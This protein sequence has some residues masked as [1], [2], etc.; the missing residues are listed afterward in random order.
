MK[1]RKSNFELMRIISMLMIIMWHLVRQGGILDN[2]STMLNV[3]LKY[4]TTLLVVHVNSFVILSGY[5]Q[6]SQ[7]FKFSKFLKLVGL[8]WFYKVIFLI[9]TQVFN[10]KEL[11]TLE[12]LKNLSPI[13]YRDYWYLQIYVLLYLISPILNRAINNINKK[14]FQKYLLTLFFIISILPTITMQE[15]FNN[16]YG[17]SLGNF[18]LLYFIGAYLRLYSI[19][20]KIIS[21]NLKQILLVL[22]F[23]ILGFVSLTCHYFSMYIQDFNS[24]TNYISQ[25]L[26][27][28]YCYDSPLVILQT[29]LYFLFFRNLRIKHNKIINKISATTLGIYLIHT[30]RLI[31][32]YVYKYFGFTSYMKSSIRILIF[33]V[34]N[35][36]ALFMLCSIIESIRISITKFLSK[37]KI[38]KTLS[39]K[40]KNFIDSL[41]FNLNWE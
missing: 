7:K 24:V 30:N 29:I 38:V 34:I 17:Y 27:N 22:C 2:T 41:G 19:D 20:I 31:I 26:G 39:K 1:N 13:N 5:F 14:Q 8:V 40:S 37:R 25:I 16:S 36:I 15:G 35:S 33:F 9:I 10:L 18:I 6:C 32:S 28:M 12:I 3:L 11:T 23:C 21:H 4:V